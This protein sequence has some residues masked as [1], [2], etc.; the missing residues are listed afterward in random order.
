MV[1]VWEQEV[2][3]EC[4]VGDMVDEDRVEGHTT[5]LEQAVEAPPN[6]RVGAPA[7]PEREVGILLPNNLRQH[8][9]LHILKDVLPYALC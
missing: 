8:R 4:R 6:P 5:C 3:S 2:P 9:T 7:N 1:E